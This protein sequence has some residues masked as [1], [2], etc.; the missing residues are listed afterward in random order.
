MAFVEI[1][2]HVTLYAGQSVFAS[3]FETEEIVLLDLM[4][5]AHVSLVFIMVIIIIMNMISFHLDITYTLIITSEW[6]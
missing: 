6:L 3:V 4:F 5:S 1:V 2:S